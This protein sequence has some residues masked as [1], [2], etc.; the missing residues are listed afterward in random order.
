MTLIGLLVAVAAPGSLAQSRPDD[1]LVVDVAVGYG[2][3]FRHAAWTPVAVDLSHPRGFVGTLELAVP[4]TDLFSAAKS[5]VRLT[6][7]ISLEPGE[8]RRFWFTVPLRGSP[9]P[10][11][12]SIRD[13]GGR[14]TRALER[15]LRGGVASGPIFLVL[16]PAAVAWTFLA[17]DAQ[18]G[19][20]STEV[21]VSQIRRPSD[22]PSEAL[23]L[24]SVSAIFIRDTFP[25]D[26]LSP[27]QVA[28][29]SAYVRSGGHLIATGGS[30][31]PA[32]PL[33]WLSWLPETT[34]RVDS[35]VVGP[36]TIPAWELYVDQADHRPLDPSSPPPRPLWGSK[37]VGAGRAT[38]IA[39]DPSSP[40]L[41][42]AVGMELREQAARYVLGDSLR[43]RSGDL[44]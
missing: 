10:L 36:F 14:T 7:P 17:E 16:D 27:E 32:F 39:F 19:G 8:S 42:S 1:G 34:G 2:G 38:I 5:Y 21:V 31:P 18:P 26:A 35:Y 12:V 28:A 29:I 22:L 41:A 43:P 11:T 30:A 4:R 9:Y 40:V 15:E 44:R 23:A 6:Q 3:R 37:Q 24:S 13:R 33:A 20:V 25:L